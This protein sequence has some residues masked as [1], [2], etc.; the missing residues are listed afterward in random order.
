MGNACLACLTGTY[1][2]IDRWCHVSDLLAPIKGRSRDGLYE[3]ILADNEREAVADLLQ[4]L[5]N[6]CYQ[7]LS[8][9]PLHPPL[10]LSLFTALVIVITNYSVILAK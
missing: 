9:R 10:S 3:P 1:S 7:L 4:Y 6:V 2:K 8:T 5:E